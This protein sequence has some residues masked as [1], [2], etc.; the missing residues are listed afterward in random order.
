MEKVNNVA[1]V[2]ITIEE[3]FDLR[4]KAEQGIYIANKLGELENRTFELD[5]RLFEL[6]DKI[7]KWKQ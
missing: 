4:T 3:Y 5:R 1:T 2:T 7:R 6:E